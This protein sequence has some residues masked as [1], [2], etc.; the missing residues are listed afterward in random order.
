MNKICYKKLKFFVFGFSIFFITFLFITIFPQITSAAPSLTLTNAE[1]NSDTQINLRW[2]TTPNAVEYEIFRVGLV[3]PINTIYYMDIE[4]DFHEYIDTGLEPNTLYTYR[5]EARDQNG[6]VLYTYGPES[7]TTDNIKKPK[8][9]SAYLDINTNK[10]VITWENDTLATND[11]YVYEVNTGTQIAGPINSV[12]SYISFSDPILNSGT[13]NSYYLIA[14]AR[15]GNRSSRTN[16]VNIIPISI[17][18]IQASL[19]SGITTISWNRVPNI[20][21]YVLERAEYVDGE[22][23][24]WIIINDNLKKILQV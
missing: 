6:N 10:A 12:D 9:I 13:A 22:W 14:E 5:I 1:Y 16:Y 17:P 19:K 15:N 18:E 3:G 8:I 24:D 11:I 2:T 23:T 7:I 21:E 4:K 20:E